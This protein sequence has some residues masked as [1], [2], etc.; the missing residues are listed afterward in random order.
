MTMRSTTKGFTLLE[1]IVAMTIFGVVLSAAYALFDSGRV[2]ASKAEMRAELFRT[3]RAAIK[4]V[5]D[6]I[7]GAM[8]PD[9]AY[10]TGFIGTDGGSGDQPLDKVEFI[11][12]NAHSDTP[13]SA[14]AHRIPP[15][16]QYELQV[17]LP[18]KAPSKI[19][20]EDA[21]SLGG[22]DIRA[23]LFIAR[24]MKPLDRIQNVPDGNLFVCNEHEHL[25]QAVRS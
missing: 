6:D 15:M 24:E 17:P 16:A 4:A 2:L 25:R 23:C 12:V 8:M 7:R 19:G 11:A 3:A 1:L 13:L 20:F 22:I 14:R 10:D 5:E 9:A 18:I 21:I